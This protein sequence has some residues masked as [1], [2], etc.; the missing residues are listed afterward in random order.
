[1]LEVL[2][3]GAAIG[4]RF[5]RGR[6]YAR[7]GAVT[8]LH[9]TTGRLDAEVLGSDP[10]PYEVTITTVLAPGPPER[11]EGSSRGGESF[12]ALT[13]EADDLRFACTCPDV[14]V[15]CKHA[16][17]ALLT[18]ADELASRPEVLRLW[19]QGP[20]ARAKAGAAAARGAATR[21]NIGQESTTGN[22]APHPW[23]R[24][25]RRQLLDAPALPGPS[26]AATPEA[27]DTAPLPG[28]SR[29]FAPLPL[30]APEL[31]GAFDV[32]DFV[33]S[34]RA[35]LIRAARGESPMPAKGLRG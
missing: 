12:M 21:A 16:V 32:A 33:A 6:A 25:A 35:A 27:P 8:V 22:D 18:F 4:G 15:P 31:V 26:V 29:T 1:M 34:A 30:P 20:S 10:T 23:E 11:A 5:Q 19:R 2:A 28:T 17:A 14:E 3:A 24:D 7:E 9:V 13:P